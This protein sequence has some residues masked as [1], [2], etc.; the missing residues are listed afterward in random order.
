MTVASANIR[1]HQNYFNDHFR[2]KHEEELLDCSECDYQAS[3]QI[4]INT[5]EEKALTKPGKIVKYFQ[6]MYQAWASQDEY[7]H[8]THRKYVSGLL[9]PANFANNQN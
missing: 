1:Y 9:K 6:V 7:I 8:T 2:V 5:Q 4:N 3:Y